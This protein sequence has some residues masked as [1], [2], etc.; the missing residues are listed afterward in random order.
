[1]PGQVVRKLIWMVLTLA[2]VTAWAEEQEG[3]ALQVRRGFFTETNIGG[4]MTLGGDKQYSNLQTYFHLGVGYDVS[5]TV[6]LGLHGGIGPNAANCWSGL[7]PNS[8]VCIETENFTVIFLDL[9]AAYLFRVAERFYVTPKLVGGFT[10]LEPA[11]VYD[12]PRQTDGKLPQGARP[13][14]SG[15]NAG[16]GLGLEYATSMDHF[17]IGLDVLARYVIGPNISSL[18]FFPR[19]KYTF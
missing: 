19:I 14:N 17:S 18:Q 4:F 1:M 13:L 3:V 8:D 2:P 15:P 7:K 11:P 6:E 9:T 5:Q 12:P 10:L 16:L